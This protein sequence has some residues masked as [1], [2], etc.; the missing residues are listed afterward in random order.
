ME[1]LPP[2]SCILPASTARSPNFPSR[3][4]AMFQLV[5]KLYGI[6]DQTSRIFILH[7]IHRKWLK[8]E[9]KCKYNHLAS[10]TC[11]QL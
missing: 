5:F 3:A 2:I 6:D 1:T 9:K 11:L 7:A 4:F 10:L 8:I